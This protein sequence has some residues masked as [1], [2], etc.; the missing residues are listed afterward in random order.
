MKNIFEKT[1][2]ALKNFWNRYKKSKMAWAILVLVII[3]LFFI[4]KHHAKPVDPSVAQAAT[5]NVIDSV[6]LS[7][8]TESASAVDLGFAD[9][10]RVAKVLVSEGD[11]VHAGDLLAELDT[12]DLDASLENAQ[13]AL[14][15][16]SA[17]TSTNTDNLANVTAQQDTLVASAAR[18]L[19]S[20]NLQAV[21]NNITT[22]APAPII[23]GSYTGPEGDYVIHMYPSSTPSGESFYLTGLENGFIGPASED[24]PTPLGTNGLF[25][26]FPYSTLYGNTV[27]TVSIP[28]TKSPTYTADY[29]AYVTAQTT[30]DQAIAQA[31][32]TIGTSATDTS[33]ANAKV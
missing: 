5:T 2:L 9:Q 23:T 8:R 1:K 19:L 17:G 10:G 25:V 7:G 30:R 27:W 31:Q 33:I 20:D 28:N 18:T 14:T 6:V 16:A 3:V 13:A 11:K 29:N 4:F 32:A 24:A 15:I 22:T 12:S 26:Q 21:A